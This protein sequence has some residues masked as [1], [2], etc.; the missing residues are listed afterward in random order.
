M[1]LNRSLSSLVYF[2]SCWNTFGLC[3][4]RQ[5]NRR[6]WFWQNTNEQEV[7]VSSK[8]NQL[9]I[10]KCV[11]FR[12]IVWRN[13]YWHN[14]LRYIYGSGMKPRRR[15]CEIAFYLLRNI[16]KWIRLFC[17]S[18]YSLCSTLYKNCV[19]KTIHSFEIS[20]VAFLVCLKLAKIELHSICVCVC[21]FVYSIGLCGDARYI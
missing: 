11:L 20:L 9:F 4:I 8:E 14:Y 1:S 5:R 17:W 6:R 16:T 2:E 10:L 21:P 15:R 18:G 19:Q 7:F 13:Q 12:W 3:F